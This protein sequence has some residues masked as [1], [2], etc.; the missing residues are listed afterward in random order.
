MRHVCALALA[1]CARLAVAWSPEGHA[2]IAGAA[3]DLNPYAGRWWGAVLA[4]HPAAAGWDQAFARQGIDGPVERHRLRRA[5]IW[6][7]QVRS[8]PRH[9]HPSWHYTNFPLVPPDFPLRP[10]DTPHND[11]IEALSHAEAGVA[12]AKVGTVDGAIWLAWLL[13]LI[14]DAHQPLHCVDWK[15]PGFINGDR[16]GNRLYVRPHQ[17]GRPVNLHAYWDRLISEPLGLTASSV[18]IGPG[19]VAPRVWCLEGRAH[20][21]ESVYERGALVTTGRAKASSSRRIQALGQVY[22]D[23]ANR[24]AQRR[25]RQA[26]ERTAAVLERLY[27]LLH[28][29][30]PGQQPDAQT[31]PARP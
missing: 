28:R 9:D 11:L 7:D 17:T 21:I 20:A 3:Y 29:S 19:Q 25:A 2:I 15:G 18:P 6:P 8:D 16:G 4:A 13:H 30:V 14:G 1:L 27:R 24:L 31:E 10:S 22:Q 23:R 5:A 26:S 12:G